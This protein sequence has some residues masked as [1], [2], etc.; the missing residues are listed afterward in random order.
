M[1]Q[2]LQDLDAVQGLSKPFK[3][4][5]RTTRM[6][7]RD[8][9][10]LNRL[11]SGQ[12]NSDR[13]IILSIVDFLGDFNQ[14]PPPLGTFTLDQLLGLG[15][16]RL[17]RDGTVI[18]LLESLGMLQTRNELRFSDG[19]MNVGVEDKSPMLLQWISKFEQRYEQA[20]REIKVSLNIREIQGETGAHSEFYL[21][22]QVLGPV[23]DTT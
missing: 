5:V 18:A 9:A 19:G 1:E 23:G 12:E 10:R 2:Q 4:F 11:I 6:F 3:T 22:E 17:C 20:K 15:Y 21:I 13:M 16:Y 14:T 7:L 8:H